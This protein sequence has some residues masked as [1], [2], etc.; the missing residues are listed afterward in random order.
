MLDTVLARNHICAWFEQVN[1]DSEIRQIVQR[2]D[3]DK[4]HDE[5]LKWMGM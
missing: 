5:R 2:K 1:L 3:Q 4:W